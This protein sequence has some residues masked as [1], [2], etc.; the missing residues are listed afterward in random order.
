M[1]KRHPKGH[2]LPLHT[3]SES[4]VRT[5]DSVISLKENTRAYGICAARNKGC[6]RLEACESILL[7]C[8]YT[9]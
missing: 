2:S 5:A 1:A 6:S 8:E 9:S 3:S 4:T 7:Y